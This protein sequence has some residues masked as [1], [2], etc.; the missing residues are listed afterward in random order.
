MLKLTRKKTLTK[1]LI[2]TVN[3]LYSYKRKSIQNILK[4]FGKK[5]ESDNRLEEISSE[6][7]ID[8]AKQI[9]K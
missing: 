7:I 8:I 4:Q 5:I 3:K 2:Q 1:E 9:L 6:E